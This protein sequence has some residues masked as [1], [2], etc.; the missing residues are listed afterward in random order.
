MKDNEL[1]L[2]EAH[3]DL[4]PYDTAPPWE[5][6]DAEQAVPALA[7]EN[8]NEGVPNGTPS[9]TPVQTVSRIDFEGNEDLE[10]FKKSFRFKRLNLLSGD[11]MSY[12][13]LNDFVKSRYGST[14]MQRLSLAKFILKQLGYK[15]SSDVLLMLSCT[16]KAKVVIATAGAGKT[17]SLQ[18]EL[19][20]SKMLDK[21][22]KTDLL[23]PTPVP[24]TSVLLPHIL[25][26]NY[27][28][29]NVQPILDRHR[30]VCRAI[31]SLL[32][33]SD[34]VD[35]SIESST[36]HAFCY[37]WLQ[38][39]SAEVKL[40]EL[41]I[42]DDDMKEKVWDAIIKPRWA[43]HYADAERDAVDWQILEEL[44]VF[45]TE[46]MLDWD[47]FFE[48][49]KF[50]DIGLK[51]K[52]AKACIQKYDSM[53]KQMNLLDFTDYVTL[54]IEVLDNYP[55]LRRRLQERYRIIIADENQDFT[56]L[57]N[58]LLVR[59][60]DPEINQL[61]AVGDPDQTIY[62]FKGVSPDGVVNLVESLPQVELLGLDTNYRCPDKIVDAAKA[63]L[64]LNVLRF[65]KP[66]NTVKTG[67]TINAHPVLY[68]QSQEAQ[69]LKLLAR[70]DPSEYKDTVITYRNNISSIIMAEEL[71]YAGIP[72]IVLDNRRPFNN[73]VFR[74]LTS[75]I[76]ALR[77][78]NDVELNK[79]LY[80]FLPMSKE[81]WLKVVEENRLY[82]RNHLHDYMLPNDAPRGTMEALAILARIS[83]RIEEAPVCDYIT[84][85]VRL[86]K[87]YYFKFLVKSNMSTDPE[88]DNYTLYLERALKFFSRQMTFEYMQAE[89]A[90]RNRDNPAGVTLSTFHGLK[91]LEFDHVIAIDFREAVFPNYFGIEE[92]YA[93]NTAL[94]EKESENRLCYVLVT[95]AKKEFHMFYPQGDPS[96]YVGLLNRVDTNSDRVDTRD[97]LVLDSVVGTSRLDSKAAFVQRIL[98]NRG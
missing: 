33:E 74:Q 83:E 12:A 2:G 78:K 91:G 52:F 43:K 65:E 16:S 54:M 31:N 39:F 62:A 30:A 63:I 23:K 97:E 82:R 69:V 14:G 7:L 64:D 36:V 24:D 71:Y 85:L 90:D 3:E 98:G 51:P 17:T 66:I 87:T 49:A 13:E 18:F 11:K 22:T 88:V 80:P 26:L 27:N 73:L 77:D 56:N 6:D 44:Y 38:A 41:R 95:R 4:S 20:I 53:K 5:L 60:Y 21:A 8:L 75:A 37:R 72:F 58:A 68:G 57:M 15:A 86:Y 48:T 1:Y 29:H 40:P 10:I 96:V 34:A 9:V 93:L 35:D 28:K 79:G 92:R 32:K 25:Y 67:G 89:L 76:K 45:K 19:L 55:D 59:L 70:F 47:P 61:I 94:E 84:E 46:S 42:I 81:E 50:T